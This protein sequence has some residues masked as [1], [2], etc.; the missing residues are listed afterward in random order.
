MVVSQVLSPL[1]LNSKSLFSSPE[2]ALPLITLTHNTTVFSIFQARKQQL[3]HTLPSF[4]TCHCQS[5]AFSAPYFLDN[6][7]DFTLLKVMQ[8]ATP[9]APSIL[10][11]LDYVQGINISPS[12][13]HLPLQYLHSY[14]CSHNAF[15]HS[16]FPIAPLPLKLHTLRF[17]TH[18]LW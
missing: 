3:S 11:I 4:P 18:V 7:C 5:G 13:C 15:P 17:K 10:M 1:C 12:I 8:R 16:P 9:T 2:S 14:T 6:C